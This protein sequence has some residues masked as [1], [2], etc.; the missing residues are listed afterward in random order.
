MLTV[1]LAGR[2]LL[3]ISDLVPAE[4]EAILDLAVDLRAN[5][6]QSLLPGATLGL[7]FAQALHAHACLLL[8][9][10]RPARRQRDRP[11]A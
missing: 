8:R 11:H 3:R 5:P 9:R 4:A 1:S 7:Y 2:D 10:D 6:R